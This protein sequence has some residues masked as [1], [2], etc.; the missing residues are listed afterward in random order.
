MSPDKQETR[1]AYG[2]A[3]LALG[4]LRRDIVVLDADLY[5]STRT[6]GFRRRFPDRF[7]DMGIAE[8]DM[9]STAA[10]LAAGGLTPF[11][12]SFAVF[13]TGRAYDQ[14]RVQVAYPCLSV[15]LVGSSAGLAHGP[16]GASHQALE[17]ISLMRGLPNMAVVVPADGVETEQATAA[18]AD[19]PGPVYMRLS[20]FPSPQLHDKSYHFEI[21]KIDVLREGAD[22]ALLGTGIATAFMLQAAEHLHR[23][24]VDAS[25]FNVST[26]KPLDRGLLTD[27]AGKV[28]LIVTAEDHMVT[29]GLGSAVAEVLS[30]VGQARQLRLG[31]RDSFGESGQAS[32][33]LEKWGLTPGGITESVIRALRPNA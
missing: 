27:L 5:T 23:K 12:N 22:V 3:L 25:V 19:Y 31:V 4:E 32:E 16:D 8:A 1:D 6:N 7:F 11:C 33:L 17:D 15:K 28:S 30:E 14:V 26:I 24:G 9:V 2:N 13:L 18:V 21:G 20:R 10:G 29:G